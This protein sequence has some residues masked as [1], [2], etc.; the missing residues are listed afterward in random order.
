MDIIN[1]LNPIN[2]IKSF[3]WEAAGSNIINGKEVKFFTHPDHPKKL[4]K[5]YSSPEGF[6]ISEKGAKIRRHGLQYSGMD[7][8][9]GT[10]T[11]FTGA[12]SLRE[13][14]QEFENE[15]SKW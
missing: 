13:V 14:L 4:L 8:R 11:P 5:W 10:I 9:S 15:N 7:G 3:G 1:E 12:S 6:M 2:L